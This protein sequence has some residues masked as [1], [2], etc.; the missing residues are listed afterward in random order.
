MAVGDAPSLTE[1]VVW[2]LDNPQKRGELAAEAKRRA[3]EL[4]SVDRMLA[5]TVA[6]YD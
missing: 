3:V 1:A 5:E 4:Y 2:M 6:L